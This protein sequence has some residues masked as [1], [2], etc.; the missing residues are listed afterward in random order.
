MCNLYITS[1]YTFCSDFSLVSFEWHTS[2]HFFDMSLKPWK[3]REHRFR[4]LFR[5]GWSLS[6]AYSS[7]V[8]SG[9]RSSLTAQYSAHAPRN[10]L[11]PSPQ[12][13]LKKIIL[14]FLQVSFSERY[15]SFPSSCW[16][17]LK[18]HSFL[19]SSREWKC[20]NCSG[21]TLFQIGDSVKQTDGP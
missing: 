2:M 21:K 19:S 6:S 5:N 16:N 10:V 3:R 18:T 15:P 9:G 7:K 14:Q 13:S 1:Q 11:C 8:F 17:A 20:K 12:W 4:F